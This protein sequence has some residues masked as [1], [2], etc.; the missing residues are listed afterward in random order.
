MWHQRYNDVIQIFDCEESTTHA[1]KIAELDI[2]SGGNDGNVYRHRLS[3]EKVAKIPTSSSCI[4]A[5]EYVEKQNKV[6]FYPLL[7]YNK[8][9]KLS[10]GFSKCRT[11]K[12]STT[13]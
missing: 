11:T 6:S 7:F 8:Y 4:F 10:Q 13:A 2:F 5:L 1:I 9:R 3:S 12:A